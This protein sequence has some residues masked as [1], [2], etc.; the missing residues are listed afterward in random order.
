[1]ADIEDQLAEVLSAP[2]DTLIDTDR[3]VTAD[4]IIEQRDLPETDREALRRWGL[5]A[6]PLFTPRFQTDAHPVLK[7]NTASDVERR[8]IHPEQRLYALGHWASDATQVSG[9]VAGDG[10]VLHLRPAPSH[11][12]GPTPSPALQLPRALQT[13]CL[14]AQL[15]GGGTWR[16]HGAGTQHARSWHA[17]TNRRTPNPNPRGTPTGNS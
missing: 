10:R 5:P 15:H 7:P 9:A 4:R 2:T 12:R 6:S 3:Q 14:A 13:C 8:L 16:P 17:C 11:S 1:L